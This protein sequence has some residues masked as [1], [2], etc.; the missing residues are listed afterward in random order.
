MIFKYFL[1]CFKIIYLILN[2]Y[3]LVINKMAEFNNDLIKF[4][5]M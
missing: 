3:N 1:L 2:L 4:L 5:K